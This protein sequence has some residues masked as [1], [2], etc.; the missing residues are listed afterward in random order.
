[1]AVYHSVVAGPPTATS[2][3]V[4][5]NSMQRVHHISSPPNVKTPTFDNTFTCGR[6]RRIIV[7]ATSSRADIN[8]AG[9]LCIKF[10]NFMKTW[11]RLCFT[12]SGKNPRG[13]R[14]TDDNPGQF[15]WY[16]ARLNQHSGDVSKFFARIDSEYRA[17]SVTIH[18]SNNTS[19]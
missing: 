6:P 12:C 16:Y 18:I 17:Q 9:T 5:R 14:C 19:E 1:M 11:S 2:R 7:D 15:H 4:L 13:V 10:I 8:V 3:K